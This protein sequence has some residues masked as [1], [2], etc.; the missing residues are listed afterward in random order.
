MLHFKTNE[1]Y[2]NKM[3]KASLYYQ[4]LLYFDGIYTNVLF[5]FQFFLFIYK[6]NSLVYTSLTI[7]L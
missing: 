7:G 2:G 3:S 4:T 5:P 1:L 6:Y